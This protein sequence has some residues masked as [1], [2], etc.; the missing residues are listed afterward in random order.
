M[1][2]TL[3]KEDI[4]RLAQIVREETGNV[5]QEKNFSMLESRIRSHILKLEIKSM[6][7]YWSYFQANEKSEREVLQSL[8][9]THHTFFFREYVHFE[10]LENWINKEGPRLKERFEKNGQP[11]RIWS[12]ACSRGQEVYSLAM[13]LEVNLFRKMGIPFEILGTDIDSDSV[14][15]AQNGVYPIQEVNTIPNIY[16]NSFWKRGTGPIKNFAAVQTSLKEK[17]SFEPLNLFEIE[18]WSNKTKFDVT[19]CRNVFIY[20]SEENV[21]KVA[22]DLAK[23]LEPRGLLLSGISEP[24]RFKGWN[25]HSVGPSAYLNAFEEAK[26]N[27]PG[28][29]PSPVKSLGLVPSPVNSQQS[30]KQS[31]YKV[32]CVDDSPTIQSLIKKIFSEDQLCESVDI[33]GNGKEARE[34]LDKAKYDLITL[35]IHMPEVGGIEFLERLYNRRV[36]PPVLMVSSV[37]RTD[38]ELATKS[39]ALGAFDYVEKPAMN[40]LKKSSGEILTKAKMAMRSKE[41]ARLESVG[42]FDSSIGQKIVIPDASQSLRVVVSSLESIKLLEQIVRGQKTEYRSPPMLIVWSDSDP[43]SELE[44]QLLG[45][46]DRQIAV[47]RDGITS[48]RANYIYIANSLSF[49]QTISPQRLKSASIQ[50][51]DK[52]IPD[53]SVFKGISSTQVLIDETL[54]PF[55]SR[56]HKQYGLNV[57]DM[58]PST[59]FPSLSAEFFANLRK[60]AA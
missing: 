15:Q 33:A 27:T 12:A 46:T 25:L 42:G 44:A 11:V 31:R 10:I 51:I 60:A 20:F 54:A 5:V 30:E 29:T 52:N 3:K 16:L 34:K 26:T 47:V 21:R 49:K 13:F 17:T 4:L 23:R 14:R 6:D 37:N 2:V 39:L 7:A 41:G 38:V 36:D 18:K 40:N 32:L 48:L 53:L 55:A 50:I 59:S 9:T 8:M 24:L 58:T 43:T 22:L 56:M 28:P 35:D 19:F 45:W 57:S 1:L